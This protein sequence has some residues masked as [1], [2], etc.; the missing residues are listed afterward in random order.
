MLGQL[1]QTKQQ[2][3]N[4]FLSRS[5]QVLVFY[6][7]VQLLGKRADRNVSKKAEALHQFLG[8]SFSHIAHS[9]LYK[10]MLHP[11]SFSSKSATIKNLLVVRSFFEKLGIEEAFQL[12]DKDC[13][14][15]KKELDKNR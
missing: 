8:L 13:E 2:E 11:L 3:E 9:E 7:I 12:I 4:P 5:Q 14:Q 1:L 6:Y 15:L 10:K